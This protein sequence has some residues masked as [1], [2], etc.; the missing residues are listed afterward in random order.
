MRNY[1]YLNTENGGLTNDRYITH[2]DDFTDNKRPIDRQSYPTRFTNT[3][4]RNVGGQFYLTHRY[5]LGFYREMTEREKQEEALKQ[6]LRRRLEELRTKKENGQLPDGEAP[7]RRPELDMPSQLPEQT[8]AENANIFGEN[9]DATTQ[10]EE[11]QDVVFVPVSSIIHTFEYEKQS[12]TFVSNYSQIDDDYLGRNDGQLY[13]PPDSAVHDYTK[14]WN[15][16]NTVGLSLREGFQDWAKFGLTAF[17]HFEKRRFTLPVDS[18]RATTNYDEFST[19]LGGELTK[20]RGKLLTYKARGEFC[21]VGSDIGEFNAEGELRTRFDIKGKEASLRAFG[22]LRNNTPAFYQR[23][24]HSRY[25]W[26]DKNLRNTQRLLI[27]GELDLEQTQTRLSANVQSIQNYVYFGLDGTPQ[28]YES[29]LQVIE[30]RVRQDF[31]YKALGWES[32]A[33]WQLSSESS[34][35]P[36]PSVAAYANLYLDFAYAHVLFIQLGVDAH[37]FSA[38]HAPYYEPAT[39]QF[40]V[41]N[42]KNVGN[43]PVINAYANMRLKQ[44]RFFIAAYNIGSMLIEP[45]NYFSMLHAPLNPMLIKLGISVYFNN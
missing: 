42:E 39:Q 4:N 43:Y 1:N 29:N 9:P 25:F 23:H 27:G 14:A 8:S 38:Y 40:Q 44:A 17:V 6:E 35:L 26:W 28:Q 2:P 15:I 45:A 5:N 7:R 34:V 13:A 16:K 3:W 37:Y 32:E 36:L 10:E 22:Y 41:Q 11:E 24:H 20:Q 30:A 18:L 33:A 12:R 19:Y 31:R 21:L